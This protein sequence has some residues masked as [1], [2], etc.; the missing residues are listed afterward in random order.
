MSRRITMR[1]IGRE[2]GVSPMTVS[3][4]LKEDSAV[5]AETR[6]AVREAADRLGYIYDTTALAFRA[7]RSGFLAVILPSINNANFAATHRALTRALSQSDLQILLGVTGYSLAEEERLV[8]QLLARRPEAMVLTGGTHTEATRR[9]LEA[10]D[11]PLI[12]IWD[13]PEAPLGSVVGFSNFDAMELLVTHLAETG[14]RRLGFLGAEG[15]GDTRGAERRAGAEAAA[16]RLG[17]PDVVQITS[18]PP[19]ATMATGAAAATAALDDIRQLDG[20][21][22]VSDPVAFGATMALRKAGLSVPGDIAVTG[23]GDFEIARIADPSITTVAVG[24]DLIGAE[25]GALVLRLLQ[26][27]EADACVQVAVTPELM[28]RHSTLAG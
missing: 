13:Q 21:M 19:P 18:G 15:G 22:C 6:T 28:L 3:R 7:Q 17:L 23:F 14:R 12:E 26:E 9:L 25:T 4:A 5:S 24:D 10:I 2:I 27:A 8:R 20:L 11:M 1:D 16:K